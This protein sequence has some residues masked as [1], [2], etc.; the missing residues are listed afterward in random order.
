MLWEYRLVEIAVDPDEHNEAALNRLGAEGWE[1]VG[2]YG[3]Q[4]STEGEP[5]PLGWKYSERSV[6]VVLFKRSRTP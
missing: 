2:L 6:L 4:Q 1:A 3:R 5:M